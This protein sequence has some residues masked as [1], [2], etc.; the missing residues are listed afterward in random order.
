[1]SDIQLFQNAFAVTFPIEAADQVLARM[2][3]LYGADFDK[4]F[5]SIEA[6]QLAQTVCTVLNGITPKQLERGLNRMLSEKWCPSLP[7]LRN[8]CLASDWWTAELA[9]AKALR[10][11]AAKSESGVL[12]LLEQRYLENIRVVQ[13]STT[14]TEA[15]KQKAI[16]KLEANYKRDFL[17]ANTP[18]TT[19]TKK[20]L[21][22]VRHVLNN[23]GQRAAHKAFVAIY[24]DYLRKAIDKGYE[25]EMWKP[26]VPVKLTHEKPKGVPC[27]ADL[28]AKIKSAVKKVGGAA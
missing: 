27:P 22:E 7:E 12:A 25:Q 6:T 11:D 17:E 10:F 24:E 16:E 3:Q 26:P 19:L 15:E 2:Q 5:G 23:E 13:N 14:R 18:I 4:K 8:M 9:W 20:T 21:D 28:A 1:M